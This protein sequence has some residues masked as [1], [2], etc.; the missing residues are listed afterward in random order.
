MR[1]KSPSR[2]R[3]NWHNHTL[4]Y[5]LT[6]AI[7]YLLRALSLQLQRDTHISITTLIVSTKTN[8]ARV[9]NFAS[10]S[11]S[12][13]TMIIS[14]VHILLLTFECPQSEQQL[15]V[16]TSSWPS[17]LN[18]LFVAYKGALRV[19]AASQKKDGL[20]CYDRITLIHLS[21]LVQLILRNY[22]EQIVEYCT[23]PFAT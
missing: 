23:R 18:R 8:A 20:T 13:V 9:I 15:L 12:S 4:L 19:A 3:L 7:N 5:E 10:K 22:V 21:E 2:C 1:T 6:Q 11:E 16:I 14:L 17:R